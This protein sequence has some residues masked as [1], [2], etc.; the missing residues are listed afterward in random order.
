MAR[1]SLESARPYVTERQSVGVPLAGHEGVQ[2]LLGEAAMAIEVGRL[3][4]MRAAVKLDGGDFAR[5]EISMAKIQVADT[6]HKS[7]DTA[8]Q[9]LGARGYS[10]ATPLEWMSRYA[11]QARPVDGAP[12]VP[13]KTGRAPGR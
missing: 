3:L 2:W 5:K 4:T 9:L 11:R 13:N 7:V 6:L 8:I 1:R 10:K 12:A